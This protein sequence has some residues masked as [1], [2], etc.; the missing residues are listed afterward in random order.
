MFLG[1]L[2]LMFLLCSRMENLCCSSLHHPWICV[3][4]CVELIAPR[5]I[6]CDVRKLCRFVRVRESLLVVVCDEHAEISV[7]FSSV[8]CGTNF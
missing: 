7:F 1:A 8:E 4:H 3:V 2:L 5:I 6:S